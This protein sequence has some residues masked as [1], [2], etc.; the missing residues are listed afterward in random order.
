MTVVIFHLF[1]PLH[2]LLGEEKGERTDSVN[3][4]HL[5]LLGE[6]KSIT[7]QTDGKAVLKPP[8]RPTLTAYPAIALHVVPTFHM[9]V[10]E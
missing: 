5:Q 1:Q 10:G 8:D 3:N 6:G 2:L 7:F 9:S 4:L